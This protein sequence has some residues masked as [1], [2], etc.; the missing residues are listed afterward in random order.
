M[1]GQNQALCRLND[2]I[3]VVKAKG[4]TSLKLISISKK[5]IIKTIDNPFKC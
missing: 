2:D 4:T 1:S 5:E 3:I